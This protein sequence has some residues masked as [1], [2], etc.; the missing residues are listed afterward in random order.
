MPRGVSPQGRAEG[1]YQQPGIGVSYV[2]NDFDDDPD[3]R[4][5]GN[6]NDNHFDLKIMKA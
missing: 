6:K 4:D 2:D 5:D 3:D 1:R